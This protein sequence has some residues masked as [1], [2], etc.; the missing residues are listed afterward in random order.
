MQ[1]PN[2]NATNELVACAHKGNCLIFM[3]LYRILWRICLW[4]WSRNGTT[5]R[6]VNFTSGRLHFYFYLI[7]PKAKKKTILSI[8]PLKCLPQPHPIEDGSNETVAGIWFDFCFSRLVENHKMRRQI[9]RCTV[10]KWK[11]RSNPWLMSAPLHMHGINRQ[12]Q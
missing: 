2:K 3:A 7:F 5:A 9:A 4:N 10:K 6:R 8:R 11:I 12:K 1:K